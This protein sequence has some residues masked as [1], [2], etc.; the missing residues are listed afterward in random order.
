M[1]FSL[2]RRFLIFLLIP[3]L[4]FVMGTGFVSFL[5]ARK[6]LLA[7]WEESAQ[8][9]VE[10][11]AHQIRMEIDAKR[12]LADLIA[13]AEDVPNGR[14][15][16]AFLIE[17]LVRSPGVRFVDIETI[18]VPRGAP[19]SDVCKSCSQGSPGSAD[20][21]CFSDE[22]AR[23]QQAGSSEKSSMS[24]D[25]SAAGTR[26]DPECCRIEVG[27]GGGPTEFLT[28]GKCFGGSDGRVHK[29]LTIT[30]S[31]HSFLD[32][33]RKIVRQKGS[34]ACLVTS[35]G[36]YLAHTDATMAMRR[37][38]G[39]SGDPLEKRILKEIKSKNYGTILGSGMPPGTVARFHKVP[40]TNNWFVVLFSD[41]HVILEP[42]ITFRSGYFIAGLFAVIV[43]AYLIHLNTVPVARSVRE[44]S[45]AAEKVERGDYTGAL[46][47]DRSDEIGQ[48]KARFNKMI[49]GLKERDLIE[50]TFGRYVDKNIARDLM[51]RPEAL[52]LGGEKHTV[53]IMIAD[54][55]RFTPTAEG[56]EPEE[57]I[58]I[59]N[60]YFAR[61]IAVIDQHTGIIVDFYGDSV[62]VF[63]NGIDADVP[64]RAAD[65]VS[66]ALAMQRELAA[67]SRDNL[68]DGLPELKMGIGIHTGEVVVGN[69]G[70]E[71]RAK[72]G[73]VGSPVNETDRIQSEAEADTVLISDA[74][75]EL[76]S[77]L[78]VVSNTCERTLKGLH[79][80]R[81]LHQVAS[82]SLEGVLG[83]GA[84]ISG[85]DNSS[86]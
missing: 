74:T 22:N 2:Q 56:L 79:G 3:V 12:D 34:Y 52:S 50:R 41:G 42:M 83:R 1:I 6:Y 40:T 17:K 60:R 58:A 77:D 25:S 44:I 49:A 24:S 57:V 20:H 81:C 51:K 7:Q 80:R 54:L 32:P 69:I 10:K 38:L 55:R 64:K 21:L 59:L 78:V 9:M 18:E 85:R 76:L 8:L 84:P 62:L 28:I 72:Y 11:A 53:T 23:K 33:V 48:L 67:L 82:M 68:R 27:S 15:T 46:R 26:S 29:R 61:M 43:I 4:L 37:K 45:E 5:F 71:T 47:E 14:L 31:F 16:Q 70:S 39:E 66:C 63:F 13:Q 86:G 65:A 36:K 35:D 19:L 75:Y 30:V 73:I